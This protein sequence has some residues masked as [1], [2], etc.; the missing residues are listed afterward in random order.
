MTPVDM[1]AIGA[2]ALGAIALVSWA[3]LVARIIDRVIMSE[4]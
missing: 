4:E 3:A 1:F 2:C